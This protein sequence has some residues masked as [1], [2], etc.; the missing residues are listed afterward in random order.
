MLKN[1]FA[2]IGFLGLVLLASVFF[3][4]TQTLG[5]GWSWTEEV[6][7]NSNNKITYLLVERGSHPD[8]V[9]RV[10]ITLVNN[11]DKREL[12]SSYM[13]TEPEARWLDEKTIGISYKKEESHSYWPQVSIDDRQYKVILSYK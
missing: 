3:T 1:I 5:T 11:D 2:I 13:K 9:D 8:A 10:K 6:R 7:V 12:W 4:S